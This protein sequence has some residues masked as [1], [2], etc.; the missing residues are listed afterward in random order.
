MKNCDNGNWNKELCPM[1]LR[2]K[3]EDGSKIQGQKWNESNLFK[4]RRL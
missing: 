4:R 2:K 1:K 3:N